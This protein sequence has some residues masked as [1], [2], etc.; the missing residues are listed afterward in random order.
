MTIM[1]MHWGYW[2]VGPGIGLLG[3]LFW[4]LLFAAL[5]WLAMHASGGHHSGGDEAMAI[6]RSRYAR[7]EINKED[8]E[9]AAATLRA[10][11]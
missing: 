9:A 3:L 5:I 2:G 10:R 6:L 1:W 8:F 11:K 4:I 7:G